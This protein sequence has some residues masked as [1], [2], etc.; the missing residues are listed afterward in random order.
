LFTSLKEAHNDTQREDTDTEKQ[1]ETQRGGFGSASPSFR[2]PQAG[3]RDVP[4]ENRIAALGVLGF[5]VHERLFVGNDPLL[6]V[7]LTPLGILLHGLELG[8]EHLIFGRLRRPHSWHRGIRSAGRKRGEPQ[9][10]SLL[11]AS[12][13][14]LAWVLSEGGAA[15]SWRSLPCLVTSWPRCGRGGER[16]RGLRRSCL[17]GE[18]ERC[19][20]RSKSLPGSRREGGVRERRRS[21]DTS[22]GGERERRRSRDTSLGGERERRRSRSCPLRW[23]CGAGPAGD[24]LESEGWR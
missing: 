19:R 2:Q 8:C 3:G 24:G 10:R 4:Q 9:A 1:D 7:L 11:W 20:G 17:G 22:L 13:S 5:G 21:R 12:A 23:G 16:D 14:G 6:A 18:R 15:A